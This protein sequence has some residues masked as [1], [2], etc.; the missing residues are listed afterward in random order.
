MSGLLFCARRGNGSVDLTRAIARLSSVGPRQH[1]T[2]PVPESATLARCGEVTSGWADETLVVAT[3]GYPELVKRSPSD[4]ATST[5]IN[6]QGI[7]AAWRN[8][9][10]AALD[11]LTGT[12]CVMVWEVAKGTLHLQVDQFGVVPLFVRMTDDAILASTEVTPLLAVAPVVT[13]DPDALPDVFASRF[14]ATQHTVWRGIRQVLPG[15]RC[16]VEAS[17]V[18]SEAKAPRFTFRAPDLSLRAAP[19]TDALQRALTANLGRLRD[20]GVSDV[21]VPLSGGIDSSTVAALAAKVFPRCTAVTFRIDDF[22]NP[23]LARTQEVADRLGLPLHI[24]GV[25]SDDVARLYPWVIARIQEPPRHYNNMVVARMLE[26]SREIAPVVLSG[27]NATVYGAGTIGRARRLLA[28]QQRIAWMPQP[29]QRAAAAVLQASGRPR[30]QRAAD[31]IRESVPQLIQRSRT[32]HLSPSTATA[33]PANARSARPSAACIART[34]DDHLSVEDAAVLWTFR[35]IE[36]PIFRRNTR[37]AQPLGLR[38]HYPLQDVA[39]LDLA[40]ELPPDPKWDPV[41]W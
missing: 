13:P 19:T 8:Q 5:V 34:W 14:L 9:G 21:V 12:F 40:A 29:L 32:L 22:D 11:C 31:L 33:L 25:S 4:P 30:W 1:D 16:V 39:A 20:E 18:V 10:V 36:S 26:A 23:E 27:D 35:E 6:A 7:A 17:G 28:R 37:L 3:C 38:Y 15:R 24:V 2:Y 41:R